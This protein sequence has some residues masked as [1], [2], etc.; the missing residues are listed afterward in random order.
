M[1]KSKFRFLPALVIT[2]SY[3]IC[4]V[5]ISL[6]CGIE[7]WH[8][9]VVQD[10]HNKY[11]FQNNDVSTGVLQ[12]FQKT[13]IAKLH[14][15]PYPLTVNPKSPPPKWSYDL[16]KGIEEFR[17]WTVT[18]FLTEKK[19][20]KDEDYHLVLDDGSGENLVAEIP[21]PACVEDTP[22]PLKDM[23][24]QARSDFDEWFAALPN[25]KKFRQKVRITGIGFFDHLH[26]AE[27]SS[28]N[29]I[30]LHPVIEIKFLK[31]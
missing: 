19:N 8:V 24:L 14:L 30:E 11:F 28:P 7:R 25:K 9:K 15:S 20:E 13:T 3:L 22:E 1:T 27:G 12:P 21:A 16:R 23:I 31:K 4:A 18:A 10:Q 17:M 2:F 5:T 6:A 26:G 29:G